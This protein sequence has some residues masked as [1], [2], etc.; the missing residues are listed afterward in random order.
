MSIDYSTI[1]TSVAT[2]VADV[3]AGGLIVVGGYAGY[4][5]IRKVTGL[6]ENEKATLH[7]MP[8]YASNPDFSVNDHIKS[9]GLSRAAGVFSSFLS[10]LASKSR[11][12]RKEKKRKSNK[13]SG[14]AFSL[15]YGRFN[16]S[17]DSGAKGISRQKKAYREYSGNRFSSPRRN[18]GVSSKGYFG[19]GSS[20]YRDSYNAFASGSSSSDR[21]FSPPPMGDNFAPPPDDRFA[22]P[23]E[24]RYGIY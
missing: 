6:F 22:P 2:S 15:S 24:E 9:N 10:G 16:F 1:I 13:A 14:L 18:Q 12:I 23:P 3:V 4:W 20:G 8:S 7:P 11:P 17:M 5:G 21:S 19:S